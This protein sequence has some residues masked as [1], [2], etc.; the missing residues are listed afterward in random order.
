MKKVS[1]IVQ[2]IIAASET[3]LTALSKGVLNLSAFAKRIQPEVERRTL[4]PVRVGTIVVALSRFAKSLDVEDPLLPNVE[5]DSIAVKSALAELA[6]DKTLENKARAANLY[7]QKN[8]AQADFLTITH[9]VG[10]ISIFIPE[11]LIPNVLSTFAPVRPKLLLE[12]LVA[13]TVRFGEKYIETPNVYFA[14]MRELA[15]KKINIAEIIST[16]TE[17]TFLVDQEDLTEV[18]TLLNSLMR[19]RRKRTGLQHRD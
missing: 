16:F 7:K 10:E 1:V 3:E 12:N 14:I 11:T 2:E 18:F 9:G 6:F 19:S 4:K 8:F 13:L 17:L 15:V 5:L